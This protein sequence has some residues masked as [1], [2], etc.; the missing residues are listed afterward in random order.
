MH[1]FEKTKDPL[2]GVV[3]TIGAED[4]KLVVK[5][6]QDVAPA[7][8]YTDKLRKSADYSKAG[9]KKN[10]WHCIHIPDGVGMHILQTHGFNIWTEPAEEVAKFIAKNRHLYGKVATTEGKF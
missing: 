10:F 6:E 1:V 7:L 3:T 5:T 8:D 2:T 9:I 4:G